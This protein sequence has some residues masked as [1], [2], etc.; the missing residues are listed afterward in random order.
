MAGFAAGSLRTLFAALSVM[1][2]AAVAAFSWPW[3]GW[4]P[5]I[6]LSDRLLG[7]LLAILAALVVT[8]VGLELLVGLPIISWFATWMDNL[9]L[10]GRPK[11]PVAAWRELQARDEASIRWRE[12]Q[13]EPQQKTARDPAQAGDATT[14]DARLYANAALDHHERGDEDGPDYRPTLPRRPLHPWKLPPST[15]TPEIERLLAHVRQYSQETG[16]VS[17]GLT[18]CASRSRRP[19]DRARS[20]LRNRWTCGSRSNGKCVRQQ[21]GT[22]DQK[23]RS[24][25]TAFVLATRQRKSCWIRSSGQ[26]SR[27]HDTSSSVGSSR[28]STRS[29][30][31]TRSRGLV[32]S[33]AQAGPTS[34]GPLFGSWSSHKTIFGQRCQKLVAGTTREKYRPPR[35]DP[36]SYPFSPRVFRSSLG[37]INQVVTLAAKENTLGRGQVE[38]RRPAITRLAR[39]TG[40]N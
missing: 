28:S 1:A 35:L 23:L 13:R 22:R 39:P 21:P 14:S 20:R 24:D 18:C 31:I 7:A 36:L 27:R 9:F 30:D 19:T 3:Y 10:K 11:S 4:A 12:R 32:E 33:E 16:R 15:L 38:Y 6:P 2:G 37:W 26:R 29:D 25:A 5:V 34:R 17:A 40:A 8:G